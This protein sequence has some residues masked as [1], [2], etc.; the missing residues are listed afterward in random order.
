[1]NRILEAADAVSGAVE[2]WQDAR[3]HGSDS[4]LAEHARVVAHACLELLEEI[5]AAQYGLEPHELVTIVGSRA[6]PVLP[7]QVRS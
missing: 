1:M 7:I 5:Q 4:L 6:D 2:S 3:D